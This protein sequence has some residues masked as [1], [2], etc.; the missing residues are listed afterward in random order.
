LKVWKRI[1]ERKLKKEIMPI[2][3]SGGITLS[4]FGNDVLYEVFIDIKEVNAINE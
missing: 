2:A 1:I 4:E 3:L